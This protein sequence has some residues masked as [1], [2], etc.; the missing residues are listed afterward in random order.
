MPEYSASCVPSCDIGTC[1]SA[2][3]CSIGNAFSKRSSRP[4]DFFNTTSVYEDNH[5]LR[6]RL[7]T[8]DAGSGLYSGKKRPTQAEV[9]AYLP[10][11]DN[12][13]E[14]KYYGRPL[15]T[16]QLKGKSISY[17]GCKSNFPL[18]LLSSPLVFGTLYARAHAN[19]TSTVEGKKIVDERPVSQQKSFGSKPFQIMS[20]Y[21][22]GCT[23]VSNHGD[24]EINNSY[25]FTNH[26]SVS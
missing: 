9:D 1:G 25:K 8:Y 13:K 26:F 6:K 4:E 14:N 15:P 24:N 12:G 17:C 10:A 20:S 23:V 2:G 5:A 11:V 18:A 22:Y 3:S 19:F 7:F 16:I 21:V